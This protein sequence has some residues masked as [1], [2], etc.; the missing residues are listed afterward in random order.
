MSVVSSAVDT[1]IVCFAE[2]PNDLRLNFPHLSDQMVRAW[3]KVYPQEFVFARFVETNEPGDIYT[4]PVNQQDVP[5]VPVPPGDGSNTTTRN[6]VKSDP[7][8]SPP[9]G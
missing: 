5:L 4:A 9:P 6:S 8:G 2:A 7:L 1:V 3:R